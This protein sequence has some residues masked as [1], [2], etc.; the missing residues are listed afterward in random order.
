[1]K[2]IFPVVIM[3]EVELANDKQYEDAQL[4]EVRGWV[5]EQLVHTD[6]REAVNAFLDADEYPPKDLIR[7][8]ELAAVIFKEDG[9]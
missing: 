5:V 7:V 4:L 6:T 1:M 3:V 9:D 8:N 2:H